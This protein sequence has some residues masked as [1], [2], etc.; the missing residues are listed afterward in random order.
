M[1]IIEIL[2][3]LQTLAIKSQEPRIYNATALL[4]AEIQNENDT[5]VRAKLS[6]YHSSMI[7]HPRKGS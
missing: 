3:D 2:K 7:R 5:E 1:S 6:A 4:I